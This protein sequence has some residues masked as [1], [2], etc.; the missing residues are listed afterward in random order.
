MARDL[1]I[2]NSTAGTGVALDRQ[3]RATGQLNGDNAAVQ[4]DGNNPAGQLNG[5][6]GTAQREG[7]IRTAQLDRDTGTAQL[8]GHY[9]TGQL[10][11]QEGAQLTGNEQARA[12]ATAT[13]RLLSARQKAE[14]WK[15][16][17]RLRTEFLAASWDARLRPKLAGKD[18]Q[19]LVW[20]GLLLIAIAAS[21]LWLVVLRPGPWQ[22]GLIIAVTVAL[23]PRKP[24]WLERR[25][26]ELAR[27]ALAPPARY[28]TRRIGVLNRMQSLW[29]RV[30]ETGRPA[31]RLLL[32]LNFLVTVALFNTA[33]FSGLWAVNTTIIF[34]LMF[35]VNL[36]VFNFSLS[37]ASRTIRVPS[38]DH[39][40]ALDTV[41]TAITDRS[42]HNGHAQGSHPDSAEKSGSGGR[43]TARP[44]ATPAGNATP[45]GVSP[46]FRQLRL[47]RFSGKIHPG[48]AA[49]V[50][51]LTVGWIGYARPGLLLILAALV[52][53]A[54]IL[55]TMDIS[56][57]QAITMMLAIALGVATVDYI[58]WRFSVTNWQGWWIA[59]P[60][61]CAEALGAAH[62]LG[63]QFTVW[64]WPAPVIELGEDPVRH[65]I[66]ILVPTINEGVGTLRPTLEGCIAA[67]QKYLTQHPDG[68]VTIVVC[69][70]GRAARFPRW[71]ETDALAQELGV[72]C[73][74]RTSN[75]GAKAG[76]IE[77][78][79]QECR[80]TGNAFLVIFDAD[81][82]PKPDFLVKTVPA[83]AD[84]KVGWV[85]TGQYYANLSNPVSRW[86]DDQQSMF[87]NLLC[88]G[89]AALNAAFICGTN[90]VI[91]AAA[92][93]EIGGLP[94][95]SVTEDFA[96]SVSLHPRWRSIYLTEVLATGLGPPD[97]SSYLKQQGRWALGT[98]G[99]FRTHWRDILLP[100][101]DG[102]RPGQRVQYL[103][104]CTHY[105][106]GLR[107]L[108]Y[109]VC[110]ILFIFTGIPAVRSATLSQYLL[111]F[112]PYG[113]LGITAMWYSTRGV[114]GLRGIIIGFGSSPALIGSLAAVILGRRKPFAVTSK[115]RQGRRSL[116]YLG[117][118]VF[119]LLLCIASLA[120]ATQ[121]R[122]RQQTSLFISLLWVIYSMLL[123]SSFLWL[124]YQDIRAQAAAQLSGA[125]EITAKQP[126]PSKLLVR[127][128]GLRPVLN[129]GM[130]A[131]IASP[132]LFSTRLASLPI[133]ADAAPSFAITKNQVDAQYTG[134]SL[135]VQTLMKQTP[136]LEHDLGIRFSIIGR[137]QVIG[138]RF[139]TAWA[140]Q[141]AA[142]GASPWISLE[143]GVF[144]PGH[145]PP[146]T[147]DL[148]AIFNGVDDQEIRRWAVEIRDFAK[149]VF[150]T[151]L[152]QV[153][154]NW[155]VSSGVA[156][157]GIPEDVP[158]AWMHIQSIFRAA[159]ANNVAWVWAPADPLRDQRFAPPPSTIS[160]VLQDFINYP[161]THWGNPQQVLHSLAR[162]YPGK[163]IIVEVSASGPAAEKAAWLTRLGQAVRDCP[164]LYA[165]LYH[166]GGP[167]L[168]PTPAEYKS[169]SLTSDPE[170]LA[171][172]K[173][174]VTRLHAG[175]RLP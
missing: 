84:A 19:E 97:I 131:L 82:V 140:D 106:C 170:S 118:Y 126:Y 172:W 62:T 16:W 49:G 53:G 67:R 94:Q 158:R 77:N 6:T 104:A 63:F 12:R 165:L 145:K 154:K 86:A 137:T 59:V 9:A 26:E 107:D 112:V 101:K 127:K 163:P 129:L 169:W 74:T 122:G 79:R 83:F 105:L 151:V 61:L 39:S 162:R 42:S 30:P 111:H 72:R 121:V 141:L 91:R 89:K 123:L 98:L 4:P 48:L 28:L 47:P 119:F 87:Y 15:E 159:G 38:N 116:R 142:Q 125:A 135:P 25:T 156:N 128:N 149:P 66:F 32:L 33:K 69:N 70:D 146:L 130:A 148:V 161:G 167:D 8:G 11:G 52:V 58:S 1:R 29:C 5:N 24:Q 56:R 41:A 80:I 88:P 99:V 147:A 139:D 166:E 108:I 60:L 143:F 45:A 85:Q 103:L 152:L 22:V 37:W 132:L 64:P 160:A 110:P 100:R 55:S 175:G 113:A 95:D 153:D 35:C 51:I 13:T 27:R 157:G 92:L 54:A 90:V 43:Q 14:R 120:W 50:V 144:G 34:A 109:L 7:H 81:Q 73:V 150:L 124:A 71:A 171:A 168:K 20:A 76:N 114:T 174:I 23:A 93:D 134:V 31:T 2:N 44:D 36:L 115:E 46:K 68:R 57:H 3:R 75:S 133:F 17:G 10:T 96:A 65:P 21:L 102:L 117:V 40:T 138:D 18:T 78:A 164:Q 155:A 173:H 136:V